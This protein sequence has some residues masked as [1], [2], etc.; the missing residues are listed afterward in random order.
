M[1]IASS[2]V[3]SEKCRQVEFTTDQHDRPLVVQFAAN[4]PTHLSMVATLW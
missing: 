4:S 1:I 3:D 2:F